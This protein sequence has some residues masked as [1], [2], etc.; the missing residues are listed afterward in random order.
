[1]NSLKKRILEESKNCP[2]SSAIYSTQRVIKDIK[3][4]FGLDD[5]TLCEVLLQMLSDGEIRDFG[6]RRSE[7]NPEHIDFYWFR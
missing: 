4:E 7:W 2:L 5:K 1:M 3:M 6:L